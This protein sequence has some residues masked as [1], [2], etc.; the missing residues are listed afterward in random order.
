MCIRD[1][2]WTTPASGGTV[3]NVTGTSPISVATGTTTPA[4][5][6]GT[7][8]VAK[9]GTGLTTYATGDLPYAS[10]PDTLSKLA[11]GTNGYVLTLA[12]GVPTWAAAAA[13]GLKSATTTVSVSAATAPTAGQVLTATGSTAATWQTPASGGVTSVNFGT[14]GLTPAS[15]TSGAVTV[16]GTL[17]V[18]NGGTGTAAAPTRW[19]V[20][21]ASTTTGYASTA[22]GTAGQVLTSNAT[23]APTWAA[24]PA[25]A[26]VSNDQFNTKGGTSALA[27]V[28]TSGKDNTAFGYTALQ[29]TTSG[30]ENT[31]FG[32]NALNG[33]TTGYN[34]TAIGMMSQ[35]GTTYGH[36]N[37]SLGW[38]AGNVLSG[39]YN[40]AIGSNAGSGWTNTNS[41]NIAIGHVG[42]GFEAN[43]I[44]IG[45]GTDHAKAYIAGIYSKTTAGVA[46]PVVIDINGQLGTVSSSIRYKQDVTDMGA[47]TSRLLDLRPVTFRYK[48][49]ANGPLHFGLIAEE[50]DQVMPELV[51]RNP[52]GQIETVAYHEMTTMLLNE[53]QKEHR[54]NQEQQRQIDAQKAENDML[55]KEMDG[56]KAEFAEIRALLG[57]AR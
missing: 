5:S 28:T 53:L 33:V 43:V 36:D 7:V 35:M 10:A 3:T 4:I 39:N 40:I 17:A 8:P 19:G 37:T 42:V 2:S 52:D 22:A 38:H 51:I 21:Y 48:T 18:A 47:S 12:G 20:I 29:V 55:R 13:T 44:R 27:A 24:V 30:V 25:A 16:A 50:V 57:S 6:L 23:S 41:N 46:T 11:A 32:S 49:Q 26:I 14:T 45:N 15:A 34:N 54:V 56:L 9:G 31:A 1:R